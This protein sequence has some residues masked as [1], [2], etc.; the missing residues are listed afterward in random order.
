MLPLDLDLDIC[1]AG[2]G[3]AYSPQQVTPPTLTT[4]PTL[5]LDTALQE[6]LA[7]HRRLAAARKE[8]IVAQLL[9][10]S[11]RS[12][13]NPDVTFAPALDQFN[14]TNEELLVIQPLEVNGTRTARIRAAQAQLGVS[15]AALA[16][17]TREVVGEVKAAYITLWR[18]REVR[19]LTKTLLEIAREVHRLAQNQVELGSR[20]G[21]DL[22][23]TGLAITQ[24]QQQETLA[25]S[26]VR[27]AEA[28]LNA[29]M[30]RLPEAPLPNVE[31]PVSKME[32][33]LVELVMAGA[34]TARTETEEEGAHA[35]ALR[36]EAALARAEGNP[37]VALQFRSQYVTF[38]RPKRSD[39]GFSLAI[40]LPLV[41]WGARKYRIQQAETAALAQEDRIEG[42]RQQIRREVVQALA[43]LEGAKA[44]LASFAEAL[45]Q[46]QKL[47]KASQLGFE[48]GKTSV[49]AVL[50][51]Q[52]TYRATLTEYVQAQ[53]ELALAQ[54]ELNRA[55]GGTK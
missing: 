1:V 6:A 47:L 32:V 10:R 49:L 27:Q 22:A 30:G 4:A 18:E 13:T 11:A 44:V 40:R 14:G 51:A 38:Q 46:A 2:L 48:E 34:L 55:M 24:A 52:R 21:V 15:I 50:E 36:Q 41:D 25:L 3:I 33:P 9:V 19:A 37:D 26:R 5:T 23:Q 17:E 28:T 53:A 7:R 29:A 8:T 42:A 43:R 20:P 12:L 39:Y 31:L 54:A 35:E 16:I 45:P